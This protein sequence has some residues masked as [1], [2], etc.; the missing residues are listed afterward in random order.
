MRIALLW[1]I[2]AL[3]C[4]AGPL[5]R[6]TDLGSL[7]GG[8]SGA[9]AISPG[10]AAVGWSLNGA[11][12]DTSV[13]FGA[14]PTALGIGRAQGINDAGTVVGTEYTPTGPQA[15]VWSS[16]GSATSI[17][18]PDSYALAINAAGQVAGA[19]NGQAFLY[20]NGELE[21]VNVGGLGSTAYGINNSG[22]VVGTVETS[23]GV[24]RGF[25]ALPGG[26]IVS[27]IGNYAMA[28]S[29]AG[30]VA[31]HVRGSGGWLQAFV[32]QNG[33][34]VRLG[35]LGGLMSFGYGVN[36]AGW[37]VGYSNRADGSI[38]AFLYR[39]GILYDLN[40]LVPE[41]NGWL[42]QTAYAINNNGQIV[43][44]GLVDGQ[45][46]AFRLDLLP[47]I[48]PLAL[49]SGE[50]AP[51][52]PVTNN[53]EPASLLLIGGGLAAVGLRKYLRR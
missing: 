4:Y 51:P 45:P 25:L 31:G 15:T 12:E 32:W 48:A 36:A 46:R 35:T 50:T 42:L 41:L 33:Q 14:S 28:V 24:F 8:Q 34:L 53:P 39:D 40:A 16:N 37:T 1:L 43:G 3:S 19:S 6:L 2:M 13:L 23:G 52:D 17:A 7:P 10:G 21:Y 22:W 27:N 30:H 18:G 49:L 26:G 29:D 11:Y 5:Y 38:A 47:Q 44:S 20:S 9:T